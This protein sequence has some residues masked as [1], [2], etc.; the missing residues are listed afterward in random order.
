MNYYIDETAM[1]IEEKNIYTAVEI[2]TLVPMQGIAIIEAFVQQNRW[3]KSFLPACRNKFVPRTENKKRL[4]TIISEKI[5]GG[6]FG[7]SIDNWLLTLTQ[8]RWNKKEQQHNLNAKGVCMGMLAGKHFAKPDPENF[9][10]K[11]LT[12]YQ[13]KTEAL[14]EMVSKVQALAG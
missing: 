3:T 11:I 6:K 14:L 13:N 2:I 10:H 12:Q 7:N 1:E 9:Q 4:I 8:K 5:L